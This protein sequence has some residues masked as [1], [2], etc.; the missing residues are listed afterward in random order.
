MARGL[1]ESALWVFGA[2]ALILFVALASYDRADPAFSSTGQEGPVTNLIGPFGAWLSD[3]FFV[4][5]GGPSYLFPVMLG[6]A[7]WAIYQERRSPEPLDRRSLG[8]RGAG[9]ALALAT[10]C[11]LATLHFS[12]G[13]LP[14][15][16]GG[17]LGALVGDGLASMLSFLGATLLLLAVWLGSVSLFTGVSY[18]KMWPA[19]STEMIRFSGSVSRTTLVSLGKSTLMDVVTTGM[20]IRKMISSTSITSTSGVVLMVP[21]ISSS[22]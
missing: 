15:T 19:L 16:A 2:L 10:S 18:R 6:F 1:R 4:L 11:G 8:L 14:N 7:G 5:F 13:S 9:F 20:V 17:V 3:L 22:S 21:M 12:G